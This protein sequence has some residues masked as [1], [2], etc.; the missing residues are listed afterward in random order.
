VWLHAQYVLGHRHHHADGPGAKNGILLVDFINQSR[1]EGM[2]RTEAI[3]AAGRVRL[4]PIMMTSL[5][6]IFGMLPMAIGGSE[7]AETRAPMAFAI[8]G[9]MVSSTV[10]TLIVLP[11]VYSY[12]DSL[13]NG[14]ASAWGW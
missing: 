8:I 2:A 6:M 12:L 3:I 9:G 10:L 11:V 14:C 1:R 4:R 13:R 5:A 7:G